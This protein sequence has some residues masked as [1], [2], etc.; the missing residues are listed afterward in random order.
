MWILTI[1]LLLANGD[2]R[3]LTHEIAAPSHA[4]EMRCRAL[5]EDAWKLNEAGFHVIAASCS[6]GS[7]A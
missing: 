5:A 7:E 4:A 3:A 2:V 1:L 6:R